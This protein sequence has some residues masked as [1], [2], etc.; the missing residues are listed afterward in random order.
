M[1]LPTF[2]PLPTNRCQGLNDCFVGAA[3][4][5]KVSDRDWHRDSDRDA[6][7]EEDG[8][9]KMDRVDA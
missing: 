8:Q 9:T 7:E 3:T 2:S 4:A 5:H 6:N 1:L